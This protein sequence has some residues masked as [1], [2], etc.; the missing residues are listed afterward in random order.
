MFHT[1]PKH[2]DREAGGMTLRVLLL[3]LLRAVAIVAGSAL[4]ALAIAWTTRVAVDAFSTRPTIHH[5]APIPPNTVHDGV[6]ITP[7]QL[8]G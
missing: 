4:L 2:R 5:Q 3:N 7:R 6:V 8:N 1:L